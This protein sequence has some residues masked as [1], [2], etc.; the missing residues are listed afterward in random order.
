MSMDRGGS[1]SRG[2]RNLNGSP[3]ERKAEEVVLDQTPS[4]ASNNINQDICFSENKDRVVELVKESP[5]ASESLRQDPSLPLCNGKSRAVDSDQETLNTTTPEESLSRDKGKGKSAKY[6]IRFDIYN[7]P[8]QSA[9]EGIIADLEDQPEHTGV[10]CDGPLC[11]E[12]QTHI[13]GHRYK[14]TVC[15][16]VDFCSECIASCNN[17]HD[18]RHAMVKCLLPT[19][20]QILRKIDES[21]KRAVLSGLGD[22]TLKLDDIMH[23]VHAETK[24]PA[25]IPSTTESLDEV[26]EAADFVILRSRL[27]GPKPRT[28]R[29]IETNSIPDDDRFVTSY[30]VDE[31]LNVSI[32]HRPFDSPP[33][34]VRDEGVMHHQD[35]DLLMKV[36]TGQISQFRYPSDGK[37]FRDARAGRPAT[38]LIDLKP[39]RFD[40]KLECNMRE[41]NLAEG[42]VY[43]ALS[44]TWKETAYERAHHATWTKEVDETFKSMS[45]YS[46]AIYCGDS[47]IQVT[48]GLRDA[49]RKLRDPVETKTYWI[50]QLSI[51]QGNL[52]ERAFQVQVMGH[53]YNRAKRVIVWTGD[54]D[55][56]TKPAFDIIRKLATAWSISRKLTLTPE[57]LVAD[58]VLDLPSFESSEWRSLLNFLL[59]PVFGRIWVIQEIVLA[60]DVVVRCGDEHITWSELSSAASLLAETPWLETLQSHYAHQKQ[61]NSQL[62]L[63]HIVTIKGFREDFH[64]LTELSIVRLLYS[65]GMFEASDPRDKIYSILGIRGARFGLRTS[66]DF[67]VDYKK[68]TQEVFTETTKAIIMGDSSFDICGINGSFSSKT[69]TGLPSWVPDYTS[70]S[71]SVATSFS[72][73][74]PPSP[75]SASID[76]E[77]FAIWPYENQR[78][79]L[80]A[81][82]QKADTIVTIAQK[83]ISNSDLLATLISEWTSLISR[84]PDYV[85]G[86]FTPDVFWRTCVADTTLRWRRSPAPLSYHQSL[87]AFFLEHVSRYEEFSNDPQG[88]QWNPVLATLVND[89]LHT[90]SQ[91]GVN[92]DIPIG[93]PDPEAILAFLGICNNRRFFVTAKNYFGIGPI[94]AEVGDEVHILSGARVPFVFRKINPDDISLPDEHDPEIQSYNMIGE[95]YVHGLMKGE[96]LKSNGFEWSGICIH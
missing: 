36:M 32:T 91:N 21:S 76:S 64:G 77:S 48:V 50:D 8:D 75:Y 20:F 26:S 41:V 95:T 40:D 65:S 57:E 68:S 60:Q 70:S 34:A 88:S 66:N 35:A 44:Y 3:M 11:K 86:E 33:A 89:A 52:S 7:I 22:A 9:A 10:M 12:S 73:P 82:S 30:R 53:I 58:L 39:G 55:G 37:F 49:L 69:I 80:V 1:D 18:A 62:R 28:S 25:P 2:S 24:R 13:K 45:K 83:T 90:T 51:D 42:P 96:A 94:D 15:D 46:H 63:G 67:Q 4:D 38:R 85:T 84:G 16:N 54:E 71:T 19:T 47:F 72:R 61:R 78:N 31:A 56:D 74:D 87:A 5:D 81:S 43:E 59:R 79:I 93:D 23:V 14:C 29:F 92:D 17:Y 27:D 6:R